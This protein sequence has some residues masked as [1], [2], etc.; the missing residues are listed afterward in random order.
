[1][2]ISNEDVIRSF[3]A[4]FDPP[5]NVVRTEKIDGKPCDDAWM[6]AAYDAETKLGVTA[7]AW[8]KEDPWAFEVHF[9]VLRDDFQIHMRCDGNA[10][11]LGRFFAITMAA[12]K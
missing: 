7:L 4:Q 6:A 8:D 12:H 2:T 9:E 3:A 1:M 5:L 11:S 10:E